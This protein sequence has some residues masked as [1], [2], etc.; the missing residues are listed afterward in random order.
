M[1]D[2]SKFSLDVLKCKLNEDMNELN[3]LDL[4]TFTL[5]P[6]VAELTEEIS[7]LTAAIESKEDK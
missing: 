1:V 2:Y 5:N 7:A 3:S 6:R 4:I